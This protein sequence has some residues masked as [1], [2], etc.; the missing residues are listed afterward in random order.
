MPHRPSKLCPGT[1]VC[2][3]SCGGAVF[4][5]SIRNGDGFFR[6][7]HKVGQQSHRRNCGQH[8]Y[9]HCTARLCTV[10]AVTKLERDYFEADQSTPDEILTALGAKLAQ[11]A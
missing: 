5:A 6:C 8:F 3:P 1:R 2:C 9:V 11:V 10:L 4:G 7:D